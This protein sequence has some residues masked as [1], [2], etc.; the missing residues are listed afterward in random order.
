[1]SSFAPD[2]WLHGSLV[3]PDWSALLP[4]PN[5]AFFVPTLEAA[6]VANVVVRLFAPLCLGLTL[7]VRRPQVPNSLSYM[8]L[9]T[10]NKHSLS[11]ARLINRAGNVRRRPC[12]VSPLPMLPFCDLGYRGE[13]RLCSAGRP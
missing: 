2:L 11:T 4:D 7:S 13:R 12:L 5:S 3:Q 8:R 6:A 9:N 10:A 1:M